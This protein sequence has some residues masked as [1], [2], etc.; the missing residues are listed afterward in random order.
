MPE[1]MINYLAV[2]ISA[3]ATM[4]IGALWYSPILFGKIWI[5]LS[6]VTQKKIEEA[7][8]KG[9][10]KSYLFTFIGSLITAYVLAHFVD[11]L[12][13]TTASGGAQLAFWLWLGFIAPVN[14]GMVLWE[15]KPF[16]LF[17]LNTLHHLVSLIVIAII[18]SVW[19]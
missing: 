1:V 19:V 12:E 15:G 18:L 9:M 7:K 6:G 5:E 10:S 16:K 13:A 3:I 17:L 2:L 11:Y 4:V 8:K 14:L